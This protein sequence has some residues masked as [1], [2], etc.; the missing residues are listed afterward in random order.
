M[1]QQADN[2]VR[3]TDSRILRRRYHNRF[4]RPGYGIPVALL[5]PSRTVDYH[6]V[7]VFFQL[8]HDLAHR[9]RCDCIL[10][11]GLSG[12]QQVQLI[13]ALVLDQGLA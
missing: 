10:V 13:E 4:V 7:E 12:R 9:F 3:I 11:L 6:V 5:D 2:P 8:Q 1:L